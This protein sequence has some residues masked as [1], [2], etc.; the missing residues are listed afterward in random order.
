MEPAARW[1]AHG[2]GP[3]ASGKGDCSLCDTHLLR[4]WMWLPCCRQA[5]ASTLSTDVLDGLCSPHDMSSDPRNPLYRN[6]G[7]GL[8]PTGLPN[9]IRYPN[10]KQTLRRR[11]GWSIGSQSYAS[12]RNTMQGCSI[13]S[14]QRCGSPLGIL[15]IHLARDRRVVV[16]MVKIILLT[17]PNTICLLYSQV[18]VGHFGTWRGNAFT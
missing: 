4:I 9:L 7:R 1:R 6:A 11:E 10:T 13:C 5:F 12:W 2:P 14:P 15:R 17:L 3:S 8:T 18:H 16:V